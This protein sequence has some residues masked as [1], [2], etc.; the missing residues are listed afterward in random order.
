MESISSVTSCGKLIMYYTS[1]VA[2]EQ[3]LF[4]P[5]R[6]ISG[7]QFFPRKLVVKL[8]YRSW[9]RKRFVCDGINQFSDKL[10]QADYVLYFVCG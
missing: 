3:E 4:W 2:E 10:W 9:K 8:K 7:I 5:A 1:F 6:A